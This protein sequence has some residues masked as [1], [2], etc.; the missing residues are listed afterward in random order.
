MSA[1]KTP[2]PCSWSQL[3]AMSAYVA[4]MSPTQLEHRRCLARIA[5]YKRFLADPSR[6]QG[7]HR[8]TLLPE[9]EVRARLAREQER[10]RELRDQIAGMPRRQVKKKKVVK[11]EETAPAPP[12]T[13]DAESGE[14]SAQGSDEDS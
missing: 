9:D 3:R 1:A 13:R 7:T 12:S 8:K 14:D 11:D 6:K 10:E 5:N 2:K 4:R